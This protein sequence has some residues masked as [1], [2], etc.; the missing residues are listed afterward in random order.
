MPYALLAALVLD[1]SLAV[2][3][4][5]FLTGALPGLWAFLSERSK[6]KRTE[7]VVARQEATIRKQEASVIRLEELVS[8]LENARV[9]LTDRIEDLFEEIKK[10]RPT[11]SIEAGPP[12]A[13]DVSNS[14]FGQPSTILTASGK[15]VVW[16]GP[17]LTD[18]PRYVLLTWAK[19]GGAIGFK[20]RDYIG[21]QIFQHQGATR[22]AEA[23]FHVGECPLDFESLWS[24]ARCH[25]QAR[26]ELDHAVSD[27]GWWR[28]RLGLMTAG[29]E[30]PESRNFSGVITESRNVLLMLS[31]TQKP[32]PRDEAHWHAA[33]RS[34]EGVSYIATTRKLTGLTAGSS[35]VAF[36]GDVA[37]ANQLL[38]FGIYEGYLR[39]DEE[40]GRDLLASSELYRS[41]GLPERAIGLIKLR[42]FTELPEGACLEGLRCSIQA[43]GAGH[44]RPF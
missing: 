38:G 7:A 9:S 2:A 5:G 4:L 26:G 21:G 33:H 16:I 28:Q 39:I 34:A 43:D 22:S 23:G 14:I 10:N 12:R 1:N 44:G 40:E 17:P 20:L 18:S 24:A 25:T 37:L 8:Q 6:L 31:S 32:P 3:I 15:F 27:F 19:E 11:T 42:N 36:Y 35:V 41:Q 29:H 13:L 30:S